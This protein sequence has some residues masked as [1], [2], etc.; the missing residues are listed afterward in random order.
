LEGTFKDHLV[1]GS[2]VCARVPILPT[3]NVVFH[4]IPHPHPFPEWKE[5]HPCSSCAALKPCQPVPC[6]QEMPSASTAGLGRCKAPDVCARC[7][8]HL[9]A[10]L[11]KAQH[12]RYQMTLVLIRNDQCK[13]IWDLYSHMILRAVLSLILI[14]Q[15]TVTQM[16]Y[17]SLSFISGET[18]IGWFIFLCLY[19]WERQKDRNTGNP[20][21]C[22]LRGQGWW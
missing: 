4:V 7:R 21:W 13:N 8:L 12:Q 15:H 22:R 11:K 14:D 18:C 3:R 19:S 10:K 1:L 20:F 16:L 17:I 6:A 9:T 5:L 2:S